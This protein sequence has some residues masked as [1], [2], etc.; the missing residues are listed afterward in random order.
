MVIKWPALVE[1]MN[2]H[3]AVHKGP[4]VPINTSRPPNSQRAVPRCFEL[5][6][7]GRGW[8]RKQASSVS[9]TPQNPKTTVR[10]QPIFVYKNTFRQNDIS[11]KWQFDKIGFYITFYVFFWCSLKIN[12]LKCLPMY[13]HPSPQLCIWNENEYL[14]FLP[15]MT[16]YDC[17]IIIKV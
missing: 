17:E 1:K 11:L 9:E 4:I 7:C 8:V 12:I 16:D 13:W 3:V 5:T 10:Y 2:V 6:W 15:V 14:D